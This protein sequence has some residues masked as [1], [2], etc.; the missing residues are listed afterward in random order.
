MES[1]CRM[2][3]LFTTVIDELD[4]HGKN[5][6]ANNDENCN[7]N[8]VLDDFEL[9]EEVAEQWQSGSPEDSTDDVVAN[10]GAVMHVADTGDNWCKRANDRNKTGKDDG[11]R[12]VLVKEALCLDD[13]CWIKQP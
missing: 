2:Q 6:D 8:I 1:V 7:L 3:R 10:E 12:T 5:R 13:M 9:S 11:A 4:H